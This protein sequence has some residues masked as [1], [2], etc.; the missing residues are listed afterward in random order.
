MRTDAALQSM[1]RM[2]LILDSVFY[3]I[4]QVLE[5]YAVCRLCF[6]AALKEQSQG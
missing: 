6:I 3:L 4:V 1:T 2:F 5:L